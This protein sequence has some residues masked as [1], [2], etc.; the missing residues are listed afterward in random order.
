MEARLPEGQEWI[1]DAHGCDPVRLADLPALQRLFD[2]II[3][4]LSLHPVGEPRWHRFPSPGGITGMVLLAE[5]HLTVHTFPEYGSACLNLFCCRA[6][7]TWPWHEGLA[8]HLG[9]HTVQVREL[10]RAYAPDYAPVRW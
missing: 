7:D 3:R 8:H 9:A 5:S 1:V 2:D 6:R 10:T 4:A